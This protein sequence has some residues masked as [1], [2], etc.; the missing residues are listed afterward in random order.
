LRHVIDQVV[1]LAFLM[2]VVAGL[3]GNA[4][5]QALAVSVRAIAERDLQGP[6]VLRAIRREGLTALINGLIIA[7]SAAL[8]VLLWFQDPRISLVV[9]VSMT[10]T[11]C[12]AGMIGIL[13][14]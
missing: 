2:P 6:M 13:P 10:L 11:F 7:W 8:V 9:G 14:R 5:S 3:S 1:A 12:W 4:G